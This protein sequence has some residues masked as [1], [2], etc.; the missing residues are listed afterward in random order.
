MLKIEGESVLSVA[1]TK[2]FVV[3]SISYE[4]TKGFSGEKKKKK[5]NHAAAILSPVDLFFFSLILFKLQINLNVCFCVLAM[6]RQTSS[7]RILFPN[8]YPLFSSS[9]PALR[10]E[11]V[12]R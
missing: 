11:F 5:E 3:C 7:C 12:K 4:S 10:R 9:C 2:V 1:E 8:S 6:Q